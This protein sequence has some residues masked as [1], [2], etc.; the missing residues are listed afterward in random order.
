MT[1]FEQKANYFKA[2]AHPM[3]VQIVEY[4]AQGEKCVCEIIPYVGKDQANVSQ[5]LAILREQGILEDRR[6]GSRVLYRIKDMRVL[7]IIALVDDLAG[8]RN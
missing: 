8:G 4:L 5:H 6:D 7:A 1:N 2:L 3:R